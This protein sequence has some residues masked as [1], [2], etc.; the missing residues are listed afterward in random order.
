MWFTGR[1]NSQAP[2]ALIV[3]KG[4]SKS[5][6]PELVIRVTGTSCPWTRLETGTSP[7]QKDGRDEG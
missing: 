1:T 3:F 2:S 6:A 5:G 4:A 7:F